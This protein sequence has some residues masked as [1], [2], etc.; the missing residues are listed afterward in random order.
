V[1][2]LDSDGTLLMNFGTLVTIAHAAPT[3]LGHCLCQNSTYETNGA[4]HFISDPQLLPRSQAARPTL[5]L[6]RRAAAAVV[7]DSQ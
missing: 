4:V 1:V 5:H 2:V 3:N 6:L 7:A